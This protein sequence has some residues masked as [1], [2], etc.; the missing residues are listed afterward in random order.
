[1][2]LKEYFVS[3]YSRRYRTAA[4]DSLERAYMYLNT[5]TSSQQAAWLAKIRVSNRETTIKIDTGADV[6][7]IHQRN[8]SQA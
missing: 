1:M 2:F 3:S 4:G 6:T 7:A 8:F 5:I